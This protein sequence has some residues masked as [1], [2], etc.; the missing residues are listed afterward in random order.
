MVV[1]RVVRRE[2]EL[3]VRRYEAVE[4][5]LAIAVA[6]DEAR[7]AA[8]VRT[9]LQAVLD[10]AGRAGGA[11]SQRNRLVPAG[12]GA[13][14]DAHATRVRIDVALVGADPLEERKILVTV[15]VRDGEAEAVVAELD[16][17]TELDAARI[18][19]RR[20][21]DVGPRQ[22]DAD[23]TVREDAEGGRAHGVGREGLAAG[24]E[25]V[26]LVLVEVGRHLDPHVLERADVVEREHRAARPQR[27]ACLLEVA[28]GHEREV[29]RVELVGRAEQLRLAPDDALLAETQPQA[30]VPHLDV[31]EGLLELLLVLLA[32][33]AV[34]GALGL[35]EVERDRLGVAARDRVAQPLARE[36]QTAS[37]RVALGEAPRVVDRD[38]A[39]GAR[40][41]DARRAG[42]EADADLGTAT[43]AAVGEE[44]SAE[45]G[46]GVLRGGQH[47]RQQHAALA[48]RV[49][50]RLL[51]DV[52]LEEGR[53]IGGIDIARLEVDAEGLGVDRAVV[54][55]VAQ[56]VRGDR[57]VE[58]VGDIGQ[59]C[60]LVD[61]VLRQP[62]SHHG[63]RQAA[64]TA[65][66]LAA[67]GELELAEAA[68]DG[69]EGI[70]V[71]QAVGARGL[72]VL[73][74]TR[75][76]EGRV[77]E[78]AAAGVAVRAGLAAEPGEARSVAQGDGLAVAHDPRNARRDDAVA[79][80]RGLG[81]FDGGVGDA[82]AVGVHEAVAAGVDA[83][84][85]QAAD[86]GARVGAG[87]SRRQV[88]GAIPVGV[89]APEH[90]AAARVD[91]VV[92]GLESDIGLQQIDVAP[93]F[94]EDVELELEVEDLVPLGQV[95]LFG[96][97]VADD[98]QLA[99]EEAVGLDSPVEGLESR[100]LGRRHEQCDDPDYCRLP[101]DETS[102]DAAHS[103]YP[104]HRSPSRLYSAAQTRSSAQGAGGTA[105]AVPHTGGT[106]V[107]RSSD[108]FPQA[109]GRSAS[110][111]RQDTYDT[112]HI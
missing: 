21:R 50:L 24:A 100:R 2:G 53:R 63:D 47:V 105:S 101:P 15:E 108:A 75:R 33:A 110:A 35:P 94:G 99:L 73:G 43:R 80:P 3:L 39:E 78:G 10:R 31:D 72:I 92:A 6:V 32:R 109:N 61:E 81:L 52:V 17:A 98:A 76:R 7:V 26:R 112:R 104:A 87:Q 84:D 11:L 16:A 41:V 49:L 111:A 30:V 59:G 90:P 82:V 95:V 74:C 51:R 42:R 19:P 5:A 64:A 79:V 102:K 12:V 46:R 45:I 93:A 8:P 34:P 96:E 44:A 13:A 83:V 28:E 27:D 1:E 67:V 14:A 97:V 56:Q 23:Q 22:A 70:V 103:N 60:V 89:G 91:A 57:R 107:S 71:A 18:L 40:G 54:G 88:L 65:A 29:D 36:V 25:V 106:R 86:V 58:G 85:Q 37:E 48:L 9:G 69:V 77:A 4:V 66:A 68:E 38:R 55:R 20:L 62:R